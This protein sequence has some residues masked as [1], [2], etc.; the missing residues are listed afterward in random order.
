M[1]AK[2][3]SRVLNGGGGVGPEARARVDAAIA[4]LRYAPSAAARAMR[5]SRSGLVGVVTGAISHGG[6]GPRSDGLPEIHILQGLQTR[7]VAEGLTP[8]IADTGRHG[9]RAA[10]LLTLF[11]RHRVEGIVHIAGHH[12]RIDLPPMADGPPIVLANGYAA[13][14]VPAV[15]PDDRAGQRALTEALIA[16]GYRRIAYVGLDPRLDATGLR[17]QGVRDA[18]DAAGI[19]PAEGS[20]RTVPAH[21]AQREQAASLWAAIE[22]VLGAPCPPEV[23][24]FGNDAMAMRAYGMLR[25]RGLQIPRDV[26]VAGC[27]DQR[28]ITEML[29]PTLTSVELPYRRMGEVAAEA[30]LAALRGEPAPAGPILV[31]GRVVHRDSVAATARA[32]PFVPRIVSQGGP[33]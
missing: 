16:M 15:L 13:E 4:A 29:Y 8:L 26:S 30:L 12:R 9:E 25:S 24:C 6:S 11:S 21:A 10:D 14:A 2:T 5:S 19:A 33:R 22:A 31:R 1:S 32:A 27:D 3:V 28:S 20:I 18:L 7:L 23:V 17:I